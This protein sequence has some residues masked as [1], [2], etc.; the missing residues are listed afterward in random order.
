MV[1]HH[2]G[3]ASHELLTSSD[4]PTSTSQ[5]AGIK[6]V[7]HC[8]WSKNLILKYSNTFEEWGLCFFKIGFFFFP[9][10]EA[11]SVAQAGVQW[12]DLSSL[13]LPSPRFK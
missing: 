8:I 6:G 11:Y 5:S 13:Q 10:M 7:S 12:H 2:V 4:P 9:K 1:F 3:Q